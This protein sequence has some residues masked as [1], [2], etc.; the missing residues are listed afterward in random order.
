MKNTNRLAVVVATAGLAVAQAD[1]A[2]AQSTSNQFELGVQVP[3]V[4]SSE[5]DRTDVGVG[6]RLAWHPIELIGFESEFN[7]YPEDFP[8]QRPFSRARIEGLFGLTVGPR[9][10][11]L[12]PF[13]RLRSGFLNVRPAPQPFPC[14]RIF[15][16]PLSC[17]LA[18]GRT[19]VAFDIGGG[20]EVFATRS[21]FARVDVGDRLV[22]YPG[23]VFDKNRTR[24]DDGF[25]SH[26]F[27]F[28]AGAGLRF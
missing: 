8:D 20:V 17:E 19:L 4:A 7:V 3:A 28:A 12:R 26:D 10:G 16:P 9:F 25:F 11:G 18:S 15:P 5:F 22:K 1:S 2:I 14:I 21:A 24:R 23:P 13:A 27:R 6:G